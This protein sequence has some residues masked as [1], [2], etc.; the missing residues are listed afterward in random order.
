MQHKLRLLKTLLTLLFTSFVLYGSPAHAQT[1]GTIKGIVIDEGGLEIP[2]VMLTVESPALIGGAQQQYSDAN[3]RFLFSKL[4]PGV[5]SLRSEK[6]NFATVLRPNLQVLIGRNVN[7][8]VEMIAQVAG[9]ELIVEDSRPTLDT[10]QTSRGEVLSKDFLDRIPAGRSYQSVISSTPGVIGGGNPNVAGAGYN[11]NTYMLDGVVI[12]DPVTGTFSVNF[13]FD[14][15]EQIEVL[16]GA[17]DPEY[18]QNLGGQINIVTETGGNTLEFLTNIWYETANWSPKMDARYASDGAELAP[19][20]FDSQYSTFQ[21]SSKVSGPIVRDKAWFILSYEMARSLIANVGVDLPRDYEGHYLMAKLTAQP[22]AAHRFTALLQA[23]PTSVDNIKQSDRFVEPEAQMRQAQG[24]FVASGHWDWFYSPEIFAE[25]KLTVQKSYIEVS[26]VPCTHNEGLGYHACDDDELENTL[27]FTTP[28]RLGISNAFDAD[29]AY[30]FQFDDRWRVR[31]ESKVSVLQREFFG[32]HDIKAGVEY[33]WTYWDWVVGYPGNMYFV[34]LNEVTYDPNT[35]QNYYWVE[36]TAPFHNVQGGWHIGTFLQDVYK[37]VDNLTFRYGVRYDRSVMA[38]DNNDKVVNVGVFGPRFYMAWD[39]WGDEKTVIRGGYGRF[40]S[41]SNLGVANDLSQSGFGY[42]LYLG[43]YF[44]TFT[45]P[46][47]ENADVSPLENT[48]TA[49]D[50]LTAPHS[51]EFTIGGAREIIQDL[52]FD[53]A[54][55]AKFTRNIYVFDETNVVWDEDGYNYIAL[56]NG[57][58]A[59]YFRL[60]TPSQ[61]RRDYFQTD[62]SLKKNFSDRWLLMSTYSYVVSKGTIQTGSGDGLA[63]PP[64]YELRYGNLGTDVRHQ[65]KTSASYDLPNDPWTTRVGMQFQYYSGYPVTRYYYTVGYGGAYQ[66]KDNIGEYARTEPVYY[67]DF[68]VQQAID[69]RRGKLWLIG[70]VENIV[71]AQQADSATTAVGTQNR[72][73]IYSRQNPLEIAL[74]LKYEY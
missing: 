68:L 6:P 12:T 61:S 58:V 38:A 41:I 57:D 20:G 54:F 37:P 55:T 51:D 22:N 59:S 53:A 33:D 4:P 42:K 74:S 45:N 7:L 1:T 21:V 18:G 47:S 19:T 26:G 72:W 48:N 56:S 31:A 60:R 44:G 50:N 65:V 16:T 15:I 17:F 13:N 34:D 23:D 46:S 64:Q 71:N 25:T 10:E 36:S 49:H 73:Y 69:V 39:P 67:L 11:E 14:A 63:V 62:V 43:E 40:N 5:Y 66:L 35:Y 29:N 9:E 30:Y 32:F 24:G 3:G 70:Q 28:G 8:T 2:G 27:D 52:V